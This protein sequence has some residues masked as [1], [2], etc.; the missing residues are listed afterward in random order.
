MNG[1]IL[2]LFRRLIQAQNKLA[3]SLTAQNVDP[4]SILAIQ[5]MLL[6]GSIFSGVLVDIVTDGKEIYRKTSKKD[7]E[8]L[9]SAIDDFCSVIESIETVHVIHKTTRRSA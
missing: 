7:F 1:K 8:D 9:L 6:R 2:N 5:E 3:H 4:E